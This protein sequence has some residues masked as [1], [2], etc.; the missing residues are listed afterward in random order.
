MEE[1]LKTIDSNIGIVIKGNKDSLEILDSIANA[2]GELLAVIA[3]ITIPASASYT[4]PS[5]TFFGISSAAPSVGPVVLTGANTG[6]LSKQDRTRVLALSQ[7]ELKK[8]NFK[9][10]KPELVATNDSKRS[11]DVNVDYRL[12]PNRQPMH[13]L[14][15]Y[16]APKVVGTS[17]QQTNISNCIYTNFC[18]TRRRHFDHRELTYHTFKAEIDVKVGKS[19]NGLLQ[20]EAMSE[21]ESED[22]MPGVLSNHAICTVHPSWRSDEYNHLLAVVNDFMRNRMDFNS[23]QMLKRSFGRDAVLAVPPRLMSLLPHWAFRYEFQ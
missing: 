20:K 2:S 4:T 23:C 14:H 8:H 17:V 10:N 12:P 19:C 5:E 6:E 18:G 15:A 11:W 3:P 16:L 7:G 9:S 1:S 13:D 21:G 22:N